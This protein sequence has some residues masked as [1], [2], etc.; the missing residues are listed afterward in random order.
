[1]LAGEEDPLLGREF[2]R[3]RRGVA[4]RGAAGRHRTRPNVSEQVLPASENTAGRGGETEESPPP[5]ARASQLAGGVR[6][7]ARA[8]QYVARW[9]TLR[10]GHRS[11]RIFNY[12]FGRCRFGDSPPA[13]IPLEATPNQIREL[14]K[15]AK[16]PGK[17]RDLAATSLA[18][19][20]PAEKT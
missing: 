18:T 8:C 19:F 20:K 4:W 11:L 6:P 5:G 14:L 7:P 2:I 16:L 12:G 10:P 1:M 15:I 17:R 13:Q 3:G 9:R